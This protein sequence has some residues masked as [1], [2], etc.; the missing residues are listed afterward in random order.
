MT[1]AKKRTAPKGRPGKLLLG[2]VFF[3]ETLDTTGRIDKLLLASE[4]RM[5]RGTN[6]G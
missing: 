2:R 4:K 3:T 6:L 5:T 1:G